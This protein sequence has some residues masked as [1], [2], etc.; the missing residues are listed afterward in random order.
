ME[1][2]TNTSQSSCDTPEELYLRTDDWLSDLDFLS[3]EIGFFKKIIKNYLRDMDHEITER[4]EQADKHLRDL[5][6]TRHLLRADIINHRDTLNDIMIDK[7][8]VNEK[9]LRE[10]NQELRSRFVELNKRNRDFKDE[11][12]GITDEVFGG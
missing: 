1:A 8:S 7:N 2:N 10:K 3:D 11:L 5:E 6:L 9:E 4:V 12:F